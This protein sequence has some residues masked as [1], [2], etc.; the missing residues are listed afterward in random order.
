MENEDIALQYAESKGF[1]AVDFQEEWN[2][3]DVFIAQSE[4]KP[5]I[6][7]YPFFILVKDGEAR[8]SNATEI[9]ELINFSQL[10]PDFTEL[11]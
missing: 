6:V 8:E 1:K 4:G 11:I 9:L 7:G 10:P 5:L 3:F 2:G